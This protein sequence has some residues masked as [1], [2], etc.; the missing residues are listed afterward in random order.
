MSSKDV[1]ILSNSEI[2]TLYS[3][4][5]KEN[6]LEYTSVLYSKVWRRIMTET[7]DRKRTVF[8]VFLG[9]IILV[10]SFIV[11]DEGFYMDESGLLSVYK[12]IYQGNRMFIDSWG[13]HQLGAFLTYP[14]LSYRIVAIW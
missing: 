10:W 7:V 4:I 5:S 3:G 14:F 1:F 12:G 2:I 6:S 11:I 9:L 13:A 8:R